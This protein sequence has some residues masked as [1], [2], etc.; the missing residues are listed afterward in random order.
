MQIANNKTIL[1]IDSSRIRQKFKKDKKL[2]M[3]VLAKRVKAQNVKK[4]KLSIFKSQSVERI[5]CRHNFQAHRFHEF[6]VYNF[7]NSTSF[8]RDRSGQSSLC[9]SLYLDLDL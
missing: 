4:V 5:V 9:S 6:P 2:P 3:V 8:T 7:H 1:L